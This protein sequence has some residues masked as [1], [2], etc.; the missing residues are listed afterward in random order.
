MAEAE[1]MKM[2]TIYVDHILPW[3]SPQEVLLYGSQARGNAREDSDIDVAVIVSSED[4]EKTGK[5]YH[6]I[7]VEL[8]RETENID[9]RIEPILLDADYD[10]SGF[11]AQV[12]HHGKVIYKKAA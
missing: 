7:M 9:W 10:P 8:F 3:I 2:L 6:E 12:K 5:T 11:L 4:I 1:L